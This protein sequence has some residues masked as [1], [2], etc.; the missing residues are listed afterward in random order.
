MHPG[1][2]VPK[3]GTLTGKGQIILK[4]KIKKWEEEIEKIA[5]RQKEMNQKSNERIRE[6][7]KKIQETEQI[8]AQENNQM[9]ANAVREIYGEV[10]PETLEAF[11][12]KIKSL[13]AEE[14]QTTPDGMSG[15]RV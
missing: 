5:E 13:R 7:R 15:T 11:K 6:L 9:I 4:E 3:F 10:T 8:M 2:F 12:Q 1:F 14:P